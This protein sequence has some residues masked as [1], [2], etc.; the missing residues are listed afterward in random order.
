MSEG[1]KYNLFH[2]VCFKLRGIAMAPP[3]VFLVLWTRGQA[4]P[5]WL[6]WA[7]GLVVFGA[8]VFVRVLAQRYLKYRLEDENA[9]ATGGPY[10]WMRNPVYIGNLLLFAG[11][12]LTSQLP[13]MIV[14]FFLWAWGVYYGTVRFEE[15]RLTKRFGDEYLAY[16]QRVNR[17]WPRAPQGPAAGSATISQWGRAAAVEWQ[18]FG[19]LLAPIL[20]ALVYVPHVRPMLFP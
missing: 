14:P 13:W 17:W 20:K 1:R 5:A 8:G 9:L 15:F 10:A 7:V 12:C 11:L 6:L 3:I 18:C 2:A 16:K 19:L 4:E